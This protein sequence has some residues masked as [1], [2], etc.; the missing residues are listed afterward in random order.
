MLID[1]ATKFERHYLTWRYF[2]TIFKF[3]DFSVQG[4][5]WINFPWDS[6]IFPWWGDPLFQRHY[7]VVFLLLLAKWR[8]GRE[9]KWQFHTKKYINNSAWIPIRARN[10]PSNVFSGPIQFFLVSEL[11]R[12]GPRPLATACCGIVTWTTMFI[13]GMVF[14]PLQVC[15][16]CV[17]TMQIT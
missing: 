13:V 6:L 12:Q 7:K 3:P 10:L 16:L 1:V 2:E 14:E 15:R 17:F 11:F 5:F 9:L 8:E 4:F